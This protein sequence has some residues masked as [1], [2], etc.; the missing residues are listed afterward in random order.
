LNNPQLEL[1]YNYA[2]YTN[3]SIFLTGKAGT[4]K[5]TFL[6]H[7]RAQTCKR[8]IVVAPTGVAA[9]NAGGVTIHSFFQLAPGLYL[10]GKNINRAEQSNS[11]RYGFSKHKINILRSIDLLVIDEISMV[12]CDL[13]DAIDEVLRR[14]QRHSEP[15]G[16]VQL[17]LI[18]DL[19]QLAPVAKDDEWSILEEN[20]YMTPYFFGSK[21]LQQT[22]YTT[23]ELTTVFRQADQI[24]VNLLNKVR[25]NQLDYA[26]YQLLNSRYRPGFSPKDEEGYITLTTHNAQAND[27]NQMKLMML[28]TQPEHFKAKVKG[29]FPETSFPTD[30]DLVLKVGAQVMFCK[31]DPSSDKLYYNGKIGRVVQFSNGQVIVECPT[32]DGD[33]QTITVGPQ[34]WTN[35]KYVTNEKTGEICEEVSG[36]FTQIPL[37]TAWAIT[38]HKSQGLTFDRCI[39][40]AGRAFSAG[41]VY[42]ALSRCRTLEGMVLSTPISSSAIRTDLQVMQYNQFVSDNQPTTEQLRND[43]LVALCDTLCTLFDFFPIA[44]RLRH[45]LRLADEHMTR[46]QRTY[47]DDLRIMVAQTEE[48]LEKVGKLFQVQIRQLIV[49]APTYEENTQLQERVKKG[50]NYFLDKTALIF[51]DYIQNGLPEIENKKTKE[52]LEREFGLLKD[53]YTLKIQLLIQTANKG[54]S[55]DLYWN[56][57]ARTTM[58][59]DKEGQ[60]GYVGTKTTK[61]KTTTKTKKKR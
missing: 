38:I 46:A 22:T 18:G 31:N 24:F 13:L 41:Q 34:E 1:A 8:M 35:A 2:Q 39:I 14:Y 21:A 6:K 20:G 32:D 47:V 33:Y 27:I 11:N 61:T 30:E 57:K 26:A 5:T 16:G 23:I 7:L 60:P 25:D 37:R 53:D 52:I 55:M 29:E 36:T 12:R 48:A 17:L 3:R 28:P 10:P 19:Q 40:N 43:R 42:V 58:Q 50:A 9:I 59:M 4:G 45:L 51:D 56:T 44:V 15:F 49:Q 54:F